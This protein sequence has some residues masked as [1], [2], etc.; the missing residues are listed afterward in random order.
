MVER[1]SCGQVSVGPAD[2]Q[3][4]ADH[5]SQQQHAAGCDGIDHPPSEPRAN[6]SAEGARQQHPEKDS[7][8]HGAHDAPT[9]AGKREM[10][11]KWHDHMHVGGEGPNKKRG[12]GERDGR[13]RAGK[14]Q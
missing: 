10:R 7:R 9:L 5:E 6:G 4:G 3:P 11:G 12:D 13:S 2:G 1:M 14:E 8:H